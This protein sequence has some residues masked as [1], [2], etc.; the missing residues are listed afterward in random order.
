MSGE[1]TL[2][3]VRWRIARLPGFDETYGLVDRLYDKQLGRALALL[4]RIHGIS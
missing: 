1:A 2:P 3:S 4:R